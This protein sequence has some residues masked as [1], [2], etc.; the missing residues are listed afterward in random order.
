MVSLISSFHYDDE[1]KQKQL[2][3]V[4]SDIKSLQMIWFNKAILP[5]P[6]WLATILSPFVSI[7]TFPVSFPILLDQFCSGY[8]ILYIY[9]RPSFFFN[10]I[11][12]CWK[13]YIL[14]DITIRH[15]ADMKRKFSAGLIGRFADLIKVK[16]ETSW[17]VFLPLDS[18]DG[19]A[20]CT[21]GHWVPILGT[22]SQ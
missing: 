22:R 3:I 4:R 13:E 14:I 17:K 9:L 7:K 11:K 8:N 6:Y 16:F 18:T 21:V 19:P 15:E 5:F 12:T 1:E 2:Q 10:W 20:G